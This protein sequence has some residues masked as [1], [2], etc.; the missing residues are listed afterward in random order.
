MPFTKYVYI[1]SK[2]TPLLDFNTIFYTFESILINFIK[3]VLNRFAND[4]NTSL[5]PCR[6]ICINLYDRVCWPTSCVTPVCLTRWR[7]LWYVIWQVNG[8][9][10]KIKQI[11]IVII[12]LLLI[13]VVLK[14]T[15][16][17]FC[18]LYGVWEVFLFQLKI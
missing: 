5:S 7:T 13:Y 16:V 3:N 2:N 9:S 11:R 14:V 1:H 15:N 4:A 17:K 18:F 8:A 12:Y 10:Q 6:V